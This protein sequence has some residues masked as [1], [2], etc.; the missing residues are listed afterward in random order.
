MPTMTQ[1]GAQWILSEYYLAIIDEEKFFIESL[2]VAVSFSVV[3]SEKE[4]FKIF[5]E[6]LAWFMDNLEVGVGCDIIPRCFI[7]HHVAQE[8]AW[9]A[10]LYSTQGFMEAIVMLEKLGY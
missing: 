6:E 10:K 7:P 4:T 1:K 9:V 5:L 3:K 2:K 8:I